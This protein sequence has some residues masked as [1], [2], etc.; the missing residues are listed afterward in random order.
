VARLQFELEA[1]ATNV[2]LMV[3]P[4]QSSATA[5]KLEPPRGSG[6]PAESGLS[7]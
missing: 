4:S 2:E 3:H 7:R 6:S 1:A 5:V